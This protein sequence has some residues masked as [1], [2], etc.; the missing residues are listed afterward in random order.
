[1]NSSDSLKITTLGGLSI[2]HGGQPVEGLVSRKVEAL[3]VYLAYEQREHPRELLA[4]L[5]WDDLTP[6]RAMSNLRTA[7]SN[8]QISI[9]GCLVVTRQTAAFNTDIPCWL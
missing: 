5:L 6:E 4:E 2:T 9:P 3:L 1:M 8:L 7:L